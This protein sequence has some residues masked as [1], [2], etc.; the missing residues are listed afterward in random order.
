MRSDEAWLLVWEKWVNFLSC[1]YKIRCFLLIDFGSLCL[2]ISF[3]SAFIKM[4]ELEAGGVKS[5][6]FFFSRPVER[7]MRRES[8]PASTETTCFFFFNTKWKVCWNMSLTYASCFLHCLPWNSLILLF[9]TIECH[10][11]HLKRSW[12]CDRLLALWEQSVN[13]VSCFLTGLIKENT[14]AM[15]ICVK[16]R[17]HVHL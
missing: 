4:W 16:V 11:G 9:L 6:G 1:F 15:E 2:C 7:G 17:E 13:F 12:R 5:S 8:F 3:P 10:W 14:N